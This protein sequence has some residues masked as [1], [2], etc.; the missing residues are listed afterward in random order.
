M[1]EYFWLPPSKDFTLSTLTPEKVN[2]AEERLGVKLPQSYIDILMIQNGGYIRYDTHPSPVPTL[3]AKDHVMVDH[4]M[5]VDNEEGIVESPILIGKLGMPESLILLNNHGHYWVCLD[6]RECGPGGEPSVVWTDNGS[7]QEVQLAPD[8][9]SFVEGLVHGNRAHV[10]GFIGVGSDPDI[11]LEKI[12]AGFGFPLKKGKTE[13]SY[14]A[15]HPYWHAL[16]RHSRASLLLAPNR[17]S[18]GDYK[19]HMHSECDWLLSC[20][21]EK[22]SREIVESTLKKNISYQVVT[23]HVPPWQS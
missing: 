14:Y 18:S 15:F 21:I 5:G 4:I 22:D 3:W 16:D 13:S 7:K 8:F 10:F 11:L 6:Y 17:V 1:K 9:A 12:A 23:V 19:Y 20:N 2:Q